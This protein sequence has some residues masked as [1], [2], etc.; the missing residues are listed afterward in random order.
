MAL[1]NE[2]NV[3]KEYNFLYRGITPREEGGKEKETIDKGKLS[4]YYRH[5]HLVL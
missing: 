4:K 3:N 2:D 5:L 1:A